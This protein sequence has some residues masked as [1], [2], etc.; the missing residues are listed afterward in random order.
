MLLSLDKTLDLSIYGKKWVFLYTSIYFVF[1]ILEN[2]DSSWSDLS[3]IVLG[4]F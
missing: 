1:L 4:F 3:T 2:F